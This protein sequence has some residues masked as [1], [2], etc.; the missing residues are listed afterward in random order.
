MRPTSD[1]VDPGTGIQKSAPRTGPT[2]TGQSGQI[3]NPPFDPRLT[4]VGGANPAFAQAGR[5]LKRGRIVR[6]NGPAYQINFMFNPS[7]LDVAYS[8]DPSLADPTKTD[9]VVTAAYIGEGAINLSLLFDR[10]YELWERRGTL[11][12]RFGVH[13]DVLAFYAYLNMIDP[14]YNIT[15]SWE[16][17]YPKNQIQ[18][19]Y[20]F[21]YVGDR[22]KYYGYI[23]SLSISY[24]HWS[25]DMIPTRAALGVGFT[26]INNPQGQA[27]GG[28]T[29]TPG[30]NPSVTDPTQIPHGPTDPSLGGIV[31]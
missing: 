16:Q 28:L 23:N 14:A 31:R 22:L 17:L 25:H 30:T 24:V 18:T 15:T 19:V 11:A 12:S 6:S 9:Q 7:T 13:A 26:I 1:L 4:S 21:L 8:Y 3:L 5:P 10:T 27:A 29:L 2:L 20:S